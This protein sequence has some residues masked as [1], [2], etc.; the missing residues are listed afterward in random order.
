[1][2]LCPPLSA[3]LPL[4]VRSETG[5]AAQSKGGESVA[6]QQPQQAPEAEAAPAP[7]VM[8]KP[9]ERM[10]AD[11]ECPGTTAPD[12]EDED[13]SSTTHPSP[14]PQLQSPDAPEGSSNSSRPAD[15]VGDEE[16]A[17]NENGA[18]AARGVV[19]PK[20]AMPKFKA[21]PGEGDEL[22]AKVVGA[23]R[24]TGPANAENSRALA[25]SPPPLLR[26]LLPSACE[27]DTTLQL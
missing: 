16:D 22:R 25:G 23:N 24:G 15:S 3:T 10:L 27:A 2:V 4:Y 12:G 8:N 20:P 14:G 26:T 6:P 9:P 13:N 17:A 21:P 1:M 7:P 11:G 19:A 5:W 18:G